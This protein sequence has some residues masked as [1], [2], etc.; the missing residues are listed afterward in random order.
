MSE[1]SGSR[2]APALGKKPEQDRGGEIAVDW[3]VV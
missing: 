1:C 3:L 2:A